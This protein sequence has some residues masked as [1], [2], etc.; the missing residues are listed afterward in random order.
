MQESPLFQ[1]PVGI[2]DILE[3]TAVRDTSGS[4]VWVRSVT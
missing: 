3:S 4:I 1:F 2:A